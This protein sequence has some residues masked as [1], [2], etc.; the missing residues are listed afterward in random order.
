MRPAVRIVL[1]LVA[2][3]ALLLWLAWELAGLAASQPDAAPL[4]AAEPGITPA[5]AADDGEATQQRI[6]ARRELARSCVSQALRVAD[7]S[8]R[9][10]RALLVLATGAQC[11]SGCTAERHAEV[12]NDKYLWQGLGVLLIRTHD[13]GRMETPMGATT[14]ML[15]QCSALLD[16]VDQDYFLWLPDGSITSSGTRNEAA[17]TTDARLPFDPE[18]LVR[19]HLTLM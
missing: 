12:L 19:Q 10:S 7:P 17:L 1:L 16:P 4:Q 2:L 8:L 13:A 11:A 6:A 18:P 14:V 5:L 9:R 3:P 15:P